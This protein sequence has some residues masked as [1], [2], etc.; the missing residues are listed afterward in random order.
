MCF[1]FYIAKAVQLDDYKC[2]IELQ[3]ADFFFI[4]SSPEVTMRVRNAG[5]MDCTEGIV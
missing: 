4:G 2:I 3:E 1:F 5:I